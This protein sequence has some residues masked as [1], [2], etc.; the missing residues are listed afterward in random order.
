[1]SIT[2]PSC[3]TTSPEDTLTCPNCGA[4]LADA[5]DAATPPAPEGGAEATGSGDAAA[6]STPPPP[7]GSIP[8]PPGPGTGHGA[9]AHPSGLSADVR[10]WA[11]LAH[12]SAFAGALV[13]IA[14]VGP[15]VVWLIKREEHPFIDHHGKEALNF[16]ITFLI[17]LIVSALLM[18]VFIGF[19]LLPVVAVAWIV[20]TI[21]AAVKASNGEGYRYPLT[22][23]LVQ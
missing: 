13:M 3:G 2:C 21:I 7:Y 22:L 1:M 5:T 15:L 19:L 18:L 14:L 11:M 6:G 4:G 10:N 16:N 23:R 12:L 17:A 8:P 9:V 20:L